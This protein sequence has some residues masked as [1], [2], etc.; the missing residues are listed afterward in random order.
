[1]S[2]ENTHYGASRIGELLKNCKK[3]GIRTAVDTAGHLPWGYFERILPYTDLFLYDVKSMDEEVH[4]QYVGVD[5]R[6]ILENLVKLLDAGANIWVRIP[7][8][9]GVNDRTC[10]M[11]KMR[12]F[13]EQN[14]YPQKIE[15]LPYHRMGDHKY[16]ALGRSAEIFHAPE[17]EKINALKNIILAEQEEKT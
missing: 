13:F 11:Q 8:V 17:E 12:H 3:N 7:I 6:L 9:S 5:N 4:L 16:P 15:L 10:E 1:M 2:T 14:G